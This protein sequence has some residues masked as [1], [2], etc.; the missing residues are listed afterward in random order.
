MS[1][2]HEAAKEE[3]LD[4]V[5]AAVRDLSVEDYRSVLEDVIEDLR[6]RL[7]AAESD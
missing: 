2:D 4:A 3:I 1:T 7:A 5:E 6:I